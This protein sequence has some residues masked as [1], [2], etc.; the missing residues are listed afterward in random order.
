MVPLLALAILSIAQQALG[1]DVSTTLERFP[2]ERKFL[3][4]VKLPRDWLTKSPPHC[5][6]IPETVCAAEAGGDFS[7]AFQ[8]YE[9]R[10]TECGMSGWKLVAHLGAGHAAAASAWKTPC[11]LGVAVKDTRRPYLIPHIKHDCL[12]L[13]LLSSYLEDASCDGCFPRFF[14]FSNL[15]GVCYSQHVVS[16]PI[17]VFLDHVDAKSA[18]G[19]RLLFNLF[20]QGLQILAIL[21]RAGVQH[22]DLT[23]RNILVRNLKTSGEKYRLLMLDFGG[24][25]SN[26][27]GV[28]PGTVA[29][30]LSSCG[31]SDLHSYACSFLDRLYPGYP[32]CTE[33]GKSFCE[34]RPH[35]FEVTGDR[36]SF[37]QFLLST[38]HSSQ[39]KAFFA[40]YAQ[41][42]DDFDTVKRL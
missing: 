34:R 35:N 22:R 24:S 11:G 15:T 27:V 12:T 28:A 20:R 3:G 26:E 7:T 40:D 37:E 4:V 36:A 29:T 2:S 32:Y 13:R 10:I 18:A 38:I 42:L 6:I 14:Y 17:S 39:R 25:K 16:V 8:Y 23:F 30:Q 5:T 41:V 33:A 9:S 21:Q 1:V 31:F 19:L